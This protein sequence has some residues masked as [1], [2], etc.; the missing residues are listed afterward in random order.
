MYFHC[1]ILPL[2]VSNSVHHIERLT[3]KHANKVALTMSSIGS[4]S[5]V[6]SFT[7][8]LEA[9]M[10]RAYDFYL[11]IEGKC[12]SSEIPC[13][14]EKMQSLLHHKALDFY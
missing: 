1:L 9:G 13:Q 3:S 7:P 11:Y 2:T 10:K 5:R 6:T 14:K 8:I 4:V 12:V